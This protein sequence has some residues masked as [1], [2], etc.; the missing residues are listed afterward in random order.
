DNIKASNRCGGCHVAGE[1]APMFARQD[2]IN[3]AYEAANSVVNLSDPA[4][5]RMVEKVG[6][7]HNCWLAS[8]EACAGRLTA[9]ISTGQGGAAGGGTQIQLV[10]PP[11]KDVGDSRAFPSLAAFQST[12]YP[13]VT[14]TAGCV[15]C[16][17]P[18]AATPQSPFFASADVNEAYNA[19]RA[20][21]NMED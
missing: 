20:K 13:L 12:I 7:G 9:W 15:R 17:S 14:G 16:H 5:S 6:G 1:Q 11:D 19:V 4:S 18:T 8:A 21:V 10:A 2:D 3:L